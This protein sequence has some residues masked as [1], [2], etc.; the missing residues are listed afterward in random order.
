M[1]NI[2]LEEISLHSY[3][4]TQALITSIPLLAMSGQ[5]SGGKSNIGYHIQVLIVPKLP[6]SFGE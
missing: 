6:C 5:Q 1:K 3:L 4:A 2:T